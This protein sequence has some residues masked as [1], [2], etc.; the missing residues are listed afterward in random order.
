M[1]QQT[2]IIC[3]SPDAQSLNSTDGFTLYNDLDED[4]M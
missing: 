1:I 4:D 3:S 2:P